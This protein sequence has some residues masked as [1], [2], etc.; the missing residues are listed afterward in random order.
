MPPVKRKA[1]SA[2]KVTKK[3][4]D[5]ESNIGRLISDQVDKLLDEVQVKKEED[6]YTYY[7]LWRTALL[8]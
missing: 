1:A 8:Q 3:F 7:P 5:D 6:D 4:K 2:S